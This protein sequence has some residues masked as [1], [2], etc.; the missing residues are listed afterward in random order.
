[1]ATLR[2]RICGFKSHLMLPEYIL[3]NGKAIQ[4]SMICDNCSA[5]AAERERAV[6]EIRK[7]S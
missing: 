3:Q 1:M 6:L 2:Q 7:T 5:R 4:V